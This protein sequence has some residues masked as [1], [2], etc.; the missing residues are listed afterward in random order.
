M[1]PLVS[2]L[3]PTYN[4]SEFISDSVKSVLKQSYRFWDLTII[5]DGSTDD[6]PEI[7]KQISDKR[8][9]YIRNET[10]MG[11]LNALLKGIEFTRGDYITLLHSDDAFLSDRVLEENVSQENLN[12]DGLFCDLFKMDKEG[13]IYDLLRVA[14]KVDRHSAALTFL[15][16]GSNIIPDI[17]FLKREALS[18]AI[19]NY[20]IWDMPYWLKFYKNSVET[21]R[22]KKVKPYYKYRAHSEDVGRYV[23]TEI[24]KFVVFMGSLRTIVEVGKRIYVPCWKL[25]K[26]FARVLQPW[27]IPYFESGLSSQCDLKNMVIHTL[28]KY[29]KQMPGNVYL[30]SLLDFYNNLPSNRTI[31][32]Q[33]DENRIFLGKDS[34]I[35]FKLMNKDRLPE[36]YRYIFE[37]MSIGFG[38]VIVKKEDIEKA[39][40]LLK[41]LNITAKIYFI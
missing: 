35:F 23:S 29:C 38:R 7:V 26:I 9:K 16:N 14:N 3:M 28:T 27:F 31:Q 24:G 13:N 39:K 34:P 19:E 41:F 30:K 32:L 18:N 2:I 4:D 15:R 12:Y 40:D 36:L 33:F 10:N 8:I 5:D 1:T 22:L 25:Q 17:F 11:Q 37:E 6:T 21:L 20:L